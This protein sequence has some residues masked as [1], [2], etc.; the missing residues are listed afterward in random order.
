M[1]MM[2]K[3]QDTQVSCHVP[4][5]V[6]GRNDLPSNSVGCNNVPTTVSTFTS[7]LP[8][9][10]P[11]PTLHR[12]HNPPQL[13][14]VTSVVSLYPS[15]A[16]TSSSLQRLPVP[17]SSLLPSPS[18]FWSRR[19]GARKEFINWSPAEANPASWSLF[20]QDGAVLARRGRQL[21][22]TCSPMHG[23]PLK[24]LKGGR[25]GGKGG[26]HKL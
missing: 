9:T 2:Y 18:Q 3:R 5:S 14:P 16:C 21:D 24:G 11:H 8:A 12:L 1:K 17:P 23:A 22:C 26:R 10:Y 19:R 6:S 4:A 13:C 25:E 15:T 20:S 7:L